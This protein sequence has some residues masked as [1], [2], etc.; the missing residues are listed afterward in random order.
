M[1]PRHCHPHQSPLKIEDFSGAEPARKRFFL[2]KMRFTKTV[3]CPPYTPLG[4]IESSRGLAALSSSPG[5]FRQS[6]VA[7]NGSGLF[8]YTQQRSGETVVS[9]KAQR[10][11]CG[12]GG[13]G[14]QGRRPLAAAHSIVRL[15]AI[16]EPPPATRRQRRQKFS[17][18]ARKTGEF[19]KSNLCF[20]NS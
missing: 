11:G 9:L 1:L 12:S 6:E 8:L 10:A 13:S 14:R 2:W 16:Q 4:A 18:S 17:R 7:P 5:V 20:P 15:C 3:P 19:G